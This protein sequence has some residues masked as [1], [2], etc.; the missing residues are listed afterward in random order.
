[1]RAL[2][3]LAWPIVISRA[4]QS[5]IGL[6]DALMVAHLGEAALAAT[7]AGALN[8]FA[9]FILPMGTVFIVSSFS[10]Q[11][12]GKGDLAGAR[13]Y[14]WYGLGV[15]AATQL[16]S[17]A[18]L[19]LLGTVLPYFGFPPEVLGPIHGYLSIRLLASGV[20]VGVEALAN[21]YGG[22]GNTRLPMLAS[23][24]AMVLNVGGNYLLIDGRLGLPALGVNG[25][26]W[27][28]VLASS[29]A[30]A[31]LLAVFLWHGKR[32]GEVVP[33]LRL[34][35]LWRMLQVGLPSGFNWFFEFFAF[36]FFVNV[37]VAGLGTTPLAAFMAVIQIN[38][39]SFMPAF[40]VASAGAIVVGQAIGAR[41]HDEV[42]GAVRLTFLVSGTWQAVVGLSYLF[43]PGLLF[44]PFARGENTTALL[45]V[46]AGMLRLSTAWQLFDSAAM[47]LAEAL[48][49]AGDTA[50]TLWVRIALGWLVFVPGSYLTVRHFGGGEVGAMVWMVAYMSLLALTLF[51]RFRTG[52]WRSIEL[53]VEPMP[54]DASS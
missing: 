23:L 44:S 17:L 16:V 11:F 47:V 40:A 30:F 8:S 38:S 1:M 4:S 26:A 29:V 9:F 2:L 15:A 37:V 3:R 34:E 27:A 33:K 31:G 24:A 14:G 41:A 54:A 6:C 19:P 42:P 32:Q 18:L 52:A 25:A 35:E 36:I 28:S 22:L 48:R 46:G 13:R 50:F 43:V 39:V 7:T 5:V 53:A 20:V 49:A 12:F 10:S 51:V 21:Y 45:L